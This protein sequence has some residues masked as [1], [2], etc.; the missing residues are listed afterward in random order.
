MLAN[1]SGPTLIVIL[2]VILLLVGAPKLPA[3]A[4]S[5]GQSVRILRKETSSASEIDTA[6]AASTAESSAENSAAHPA[7]HTGK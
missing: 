2:F 7:A 3:L 1:L 4:R 6:E 5:L